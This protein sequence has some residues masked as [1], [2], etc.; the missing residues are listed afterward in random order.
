MK[1][2][3]I[4][5]L[6]FGSTGKGAVAAYLVKKREYD[7]SVRVQSIQAGH[8][9]YHNGQPYKMRTIP[10]AWVNPDV[11]LVL[12]PGC[13]IEKELLLNEID[14]INGAMGGDVRDRLIVDHR[15]TYIIPEDAKLEEKLK[16]EKKMGSTAHGAGASLIRKL[17]R[18]SPPTRVCDDSWARENGIRTQDTIRYLQ[19]MQ[20]LVEG[21]Q[22]TMLSIHTS[23]YYPYVT[24][25]E[26]TASGILSECGIAPRDVRSV[27]GVFRSLPIRVGGN[28]GPSGS[29]ELSWDDVNKRAGRVVEPERT[30][31][32]NRVR[33]I[34]EFNWDDFEHALLVNKPDELYL[35]F[36]DYLSPGIY[37]A[38][39]FADLTP[40]GR[41]ALY[42]FINEL[43]QR[44]RIKIR[45]VGTG[46]QADHYIEM[47]L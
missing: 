28:S 4:V 45:W 43:E 23:P 27:M 10:C 46:E 41:T 44:F 6:Q 37:G 2:D 3:V 30:T 11:K 14:M 17:W 35:T 9:L 19:N 5:D 33:R 31:V 25:R 16:L 24:S 1:A 18:D 34:F 7:A 12:G 47:G 26:C 29:Y 20:V 15:A 40:E 32:T 36:A 13:F 22:G 8:T 42:G 38:R 39:T 21:C